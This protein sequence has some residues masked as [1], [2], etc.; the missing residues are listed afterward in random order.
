MFTGFVPTLMFSVILIS[1]PAFGLG[2]RVSLGKESRPEVVKPVFIPKPPVI[3]PSTPNI[4]VQPP[5]SVPATPTFSQPV[6]SNSVKLALLRQLEL[7]Q[8]DILKDRH[9]TAIATSQSLLDRLKTIQTDMIASFFPTSFQT[10]TSQSH[11]DVDFISDGFGVI[12]T[13]HYGNRSKQFIDLS[14][15]HM[16]PSIQEYWNLAQNPKLVRHMDNTDIITISP[17]I[18]GLEKLNPT[19]DIIE[20]NILLSDQLMVNIVARGKD[21]S[22]LIEEYTNQVQF[23]LLK[24]YLQ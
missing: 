9:S 20:R 17:G 5:V 3:L 14:V 1:S 23:A 11:Q 10:L 8:Q 4:A 12:F 16:D 18:K 13:K 6:V 24:R 7:I 21:A 19:Q 15:I 2:S 22:L